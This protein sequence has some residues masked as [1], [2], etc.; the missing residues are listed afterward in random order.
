MEKEI[1][2]FELRYDGMY[3]IQWT[4]GD[5]LHKWYVYLNI[6]TLLRMLE[7]EGLTLEY[8]IKITWFSK[9]I[10]FNKVKLSYTLLEDG[11]Y[12]AYGFFGEYQGNTLKENFDV[13]IFVGDSLKNHKNETILGDVNLID[14]NYSDL[15]QSLIWK[16]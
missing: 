3:H 6:P 11:R 15:C 16:K 12:M 8:L 5:R 4:E 7:T 2:N 9:P 1:T 10:K 13:E 14:D